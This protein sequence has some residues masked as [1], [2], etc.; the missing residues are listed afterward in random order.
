MSST[1][2]TDI[3]LVEDNPDHAEITRRALKNGGA[4]RVVWVKDG[5][6]ALDFLH[7]QGPW[8]SHPGG[9]PSVI[10]LD[11]GLP[12]VS[13]HE[14]LSTVKN[15]EH[16]RCIPVVMLSTSGDPDDVSR[17]YQAGANSYVVKALDFAEFVSR[18]KAIRNYWV[19]TNVLPEDVAPA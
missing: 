10:L 8:A 14:V 16:L 3:L 1:I 2:A 11:V 19:E 18:V 5:Q 15:D 9:V 17:S 7:R 13:G 4:H 12:K 6:E